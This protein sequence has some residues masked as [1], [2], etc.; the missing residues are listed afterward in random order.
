MGMASRV[1]DNRLRADSTFY[2]R[3]LLSF[4]GYWYCYTSI[5]SQIDSPAIAYVKNTAECIDVIN[6]TQTVHNQ[7]YNEVTNPQLTIWNFLW[8]YIHTS[9]HPR[10]V[11]HLLHDYFPIAN[12]L[13]NYIGVIILSVAT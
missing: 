11:P 12:V 6:E 9:K 8:T 7:Q 5:S 13:G 1:L 2:R 10:I 4:S 3:R